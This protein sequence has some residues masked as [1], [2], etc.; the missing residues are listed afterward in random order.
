M[1]KKLENAVMRHS[2]VRLFLID[3][4]SRQPSKSKIVNAVSSILEKLI[5]ECLERSSTVVLPYVRRLPV[6][7]SLPNRE[8]TRVRTTLSLSKESLY[9]NIQKRSMILPKSSNAK[10]FERI[11]QLAQGAFGTISLAWDKRTNELVAIKTIPR[12]FLILPSSGSSSLF[13]EDASSW[14]FASS[15][16]H[17]DGTEHNYQLSPSGFS[18][19]TALRLLASHDNILPLLEYFS[20]GTTSLALVFPLCPIDLGG[21]ISF[22]L[23]SSKRRSGIPESHIKA[24]LRDVLSALHHMHTLSIAHCDINPRNILLASHG[25]FQVADFGLAQPFALD[26]GGK[27]SISSTIRPNGLCT[28]F[29]RSPELLFNSKTYNQAVDMWSCGLLLAELLNLLPLFPGRGV[30]DQLGRI[31]GIL[32]TPTDTNWPN[33]KH[34]PDFSK[35]KF[36]TMEPIPLG[37]VIPRAC[38]NPMLLD[39]L[40]NRMLLLDPELRR[41]A[42]VC[43]EHPWFN[44]SPVPAV[45]SQI[46]EYFVASRGLRT[47][48]TNGSN[49]NCDGKGTDVESETDSQ[50][51]NLENAHPSSISTTWKTTT[52]MKRVHDIMKF[53]KRIHQ[54]GSGTT[55]M[56][57]VSKEDLNSIFRCE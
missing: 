52:R 37:S 25:L 29:Y 47:Y 57:R 15:I 5:R 31:F 14:G 17:Q 44:I 1:V 33:A 41:S 2:A 32:G 23:Y 49:F 38:G 34:L 8:S 20:E 13:S 30:L 36:R 4:D 6:E 55:S 9:H 27:D 10:H 21:L 39:L 28:L 46:V 51:S 43:L 48:I 26:R 12:A 18:E 35:T 56:K 40:Q 54:R 45:P 24:I 53:R 19:L 22:E 50:P 3:E 11:Q 7:L 42:S 16:P